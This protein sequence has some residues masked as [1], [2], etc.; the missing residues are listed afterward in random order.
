[1]KML[2]KCR[3]CG[4]VFCGCLSNDDEALKLHTDWVERMKWGE[5]NPVASHACR[6]MGYGVGE[7][8]GCVK[9]EEF[10]D[11]I[12]ILEFH[13]RVRMESEEYNRRHCRMYNP[14][15]KKK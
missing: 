11:E 3:L 15:Y 13:E 8:I 14:D 7:Y 1:M 12:Q 10:I 9:D 2:F 6:E 5:H 4:E